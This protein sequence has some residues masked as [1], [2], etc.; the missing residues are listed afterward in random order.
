LPEMAAVKSKDS[1]TATAKND[2]Q[3]RNAKRITDN[4]KGE[5]SANL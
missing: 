3:E 1:S 4:S 2:A 5:H